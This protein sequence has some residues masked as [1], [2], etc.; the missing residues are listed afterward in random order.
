MTRLLVYSLRGDFGTTYRMATGTSLL[1][2]CSQ[3]LTAIHS[4]LS[5][6]LLQEY[7]IPG[8]SFVF[9]MLIYN[10]FSGII[11]FIVMIIGHTLNLYFFTR[12]RF[13]SVP[14]CSSDHSAEP[15]YEQ[16]KDL[17]AMCQLLNVTCKLLFS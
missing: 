15:V 16:A 7:V 4:P 11:Y 12:V 8:S 10:F 17:Q 1:Y 3:F 6:V 5:K 9:P 14:Q 2:G 13:H